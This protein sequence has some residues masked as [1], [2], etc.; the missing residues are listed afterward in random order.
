MSSPPRGDG[1]PA[2]RLASRPAGLL[3][4]APWAGRVPHP[5]LGKTGN[6]SG[7][8]A[9]RKPEGLE[10]G[11]AG[12]RQPWRSLRTVTTKADGD[13]ERWPFRAGRPQR[14]PPPGSPLPSTPSSAWP[15]GGH[16]LTPS[17]HSSGALP[18]SLL[19][20]RVEGGAR[21]EGIR[22]A[23]EAGEGRLVRSWG[24]AKT[25]EEKEGLEFSCPPPPRPRPR[26]RMCS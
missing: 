11:G 20:E 9:Q 16:V 13:V 15:G 8:R 12:P 6:P 3:W 7:G 23:C 22:Q 21:F 4:V 18:L 24:S 1:C 14:S 2:W 5:R 26:L 25:R 19:M 17:G 10:Q